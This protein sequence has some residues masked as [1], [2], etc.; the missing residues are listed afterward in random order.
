MFILAPLLLKIA[1]KLKKFHMSA[2]PVRLMI[3]YL[4]PNLLLY[5]IGVFLFKYELESHE[6]PNTAEFII[7]INSLSYSAPNAW[8]HH[9]L[10]KPTVGYALDMT[11]IFHVGFREWAFVIPEDIYK[12][13][14]LLLL[15]TFLFWTVLG[16]ATISK[17]GTTHYIIL[18]IPAFGI[19][20]T[21]VDGGLF[22]S[23]SHASLGAY[24]SLLMYFI[25]KED[26]LKN[27]LAIPLIYSYSIFPFLLINYISYFIDIPV[28]DF[29]NT[30]QAELLFPTIL[31]IFLL[32][33]SFQKADKNIRLRIL[34]GLIVLLVIALSLSFTIIYK[35]F[36]KYNILPDGEVNA[37]IYSPALE[38]ADQ[39]EIEKIFLSEDIKIKVI[40]KEG[41]FILGTFSSSRPL[42]FQDILNLKFVK[43]ARNS[44]GGI[45][46]VTPG[47]LG[48]IKTIVIFP[49][50]GVTQEE[51]N[52]LYNH[53]CVKDFKILEDRIVVD[54]V[55]KHDMAIESVAMI[56]KEPH[57]LGAV[58]N[59]Y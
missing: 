44:N 41:P 57:L 32:F 29:S 24:F 2:S 58:V 1:F 59:Y 22:T 40:F 18:A 5:G 15:V 30:P 31:S 50:K 37:T 33:K 3:I 49:K 27:S 56:F 6:L 4:F 46:G 52:K 36:W 19:F 28:L 21:T 7:P 26:R 23:F 43:A 12:A 34:A 17:Y 54:V 14:A 20:V 16:Y 55:M 35:G 10:L 8:L 42:K 25:S 45:Y 47:R 13:T 48:E 53:P 9:H 38:F 39:E 11:Y 51:I